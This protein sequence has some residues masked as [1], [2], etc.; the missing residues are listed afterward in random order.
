MDRLDSEKE[1][2]RDQLASV[3]VQLRVAKEKAKAR[4]RQIEDLQSQLGSAIAER[5]AFGKELER[6]KSVSKIT[7]A[8][9]EETVAQYRDDVEVVE[10]RL[11]VTS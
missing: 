11:K 4:A 7:R 8:D 6:A 9:A 10:A 2:A 1:T 3:E 5:D